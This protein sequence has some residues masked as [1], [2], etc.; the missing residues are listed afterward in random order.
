MRKKHSGGHV[1]HE[2]WLVSYA[3]FI[4]LLFAFFVVMFASSQ[5]DKTKVKAV[6][7]SVREALEHGTF[8]TAMSIVLGRGKHEAKKAPITKEATPAKE[9]PDTPPPAL[10][11][12]PPPNPEMATYLE[13]LAKALAPELNAGKLH[14]S[15]EARGL[16]ISMREAAFFSSGGEIV[17]ATG[18]PILERIATVV[19]QMP[20]S[21][22]LE[23]HTDSKPIHNSRFRS[24]WELSVARSIAM[25]E[26]LR[27]KYG[28]EQSR[29]AVAG[30]AD[31]SPADTNDTEEGRGHNRRVDLVLLS[32]GAMKSEPPPPTVSITTPAMTV[33][34]DGR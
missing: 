11:K 33:T 19:R 26:I 6:S 23:G 32:P 18:M 4:T 9:N 24:N 5:A 20:N 31:H 30:Y 28:I 2:R 1:N 29:M 14:I 10:T 27:D 13:N 3:D 8:S 22:R 34:S 12:T 15:L 17:S 21:V 25:L 7:E 16:I